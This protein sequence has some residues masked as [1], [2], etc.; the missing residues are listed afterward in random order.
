MR[1]LSTLM[2]TVIGLTVWALPAAAWWNEEWQYRKKITFNTKPAGADVGENLTDVPLLIRLHTGNFNFGNARETG[3]D[4]RFVAGDDQTLLKHHLEKY[5]N[6]EELALV[7]VRLPKL[8]GGSDQD[9]IYL[10]YGNAEAVGGQDLAGTY[11]PMQAAV[12]HFGQPEP[13][14]DV[15]ANKNQLA[16]IPAGAVIPANIGDGASLS[17]PGDAFS[18]QG[19]PS[20][21]FSKGFTISCW[22][23]IAA[24]QKSQLF[25]R[26]SETSRLDIGI[27][28]TRIYCRVMKE[29][30]KQYITEESAE[31]TLDN[32]NHL[33]ISGTGKGVI[34]V[35]LDG[36]KTYYMQLPGGLPALSGDLLVGSGP[37]K[38][39][40]FTGEMDEIQLYAQALTDG[41]IR[42][43]YANQGPDGRLMAF[44]VEMMT[45][46]SGFLE[47]MHLGT[48]V[49]NIT[50]D[51]WIIIGF[52]CIMGFASA[53]VILSKSFTLYLANKENK[54]FISVFKE[55]QDPLALNTDQEAYENAPVFRI[56]LAGRHTIQ[57]WFGGSAADRPVLT[58]KKMEGVRAALE[59]SLMEET[60]GLNAWLMVLTLSIS[61]GPFLGLLGTVWGVMTTF[62]SLA[63][64]GEANLTAIAPGVAS[65]L[66]TTVFGLI[67]AIPALF[68]YN[69]LATRVKQA[70]IDLSLFVDDFGLKIDLNY[71]GEHAA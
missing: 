58:P 18:I 52:I 51:G 61:G 67:V 12:F 68:G 38:A 55:H 28:Q 37:D 34:S 36:A 16:K 19:A 24:P 48:I 44:D 33:A 29:D 15:T 66:A 3:E 71:G 42:A 31:L 26:S 46:K 27:D 70:T 5:D 1:T 63:E 62:A 32:W 56:Y 49:K 14:Q 43:L 30:G 69:Y 54:S 57:Q 40:I 8:A 7:W 35:Y 13:F 9:F 59:K 10:Y 39:D 11:G 22:V 47:D 6:L 21:D 25:S 50:L 2:L 17:S 60:T 53:I 41:W 65:A 45:E 20:L 4:L 23:K 64:T